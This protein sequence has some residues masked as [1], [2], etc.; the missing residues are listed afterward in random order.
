MKKKATQSCEAF[1]MLYKYGIEL[2]NAR[3]AF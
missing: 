2:Q 3:L 1:F